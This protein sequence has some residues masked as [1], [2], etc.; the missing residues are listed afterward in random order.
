MDKEQ[1]QK[2]LAELKQQ[3]K[4]KFSQSYDIIINIKNI[5]IKSHPLDFFIALPHSKGKKIKVAALVG[6]E[7]AEQATK[8]CDLTIRETEF[9]R[10]A[11]DKKGVKKLAEQYDYFIAQANLM[12]KVAG[13]FGKALGVKGKMPNPKMGCV[14]PPNANL[15]ALVKKLAQ[16]VRLQAKKATNMQCLVGKENQA[17][18]EIVNNVMAIIHAVQKGLPNEEQNIKNIWLKTTMG[19]PVRIW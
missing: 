6:Q 5:E 17:D 12:G 15:E 9:A 1:V 18:D 7:L 10:Y 4:R 3:P 19:K 2:A 16:S 8:F 13:A 11:A 14:V